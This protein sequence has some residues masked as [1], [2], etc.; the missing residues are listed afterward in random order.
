MHCAE[1]L[2]VHLVKKSKFYLHMCNKD[3]AK[4]QSTRSRTLP[5]I[6]CLSFMDTRSFLFFWNWIVLTSNQNRTVQYPFLP[7][8]RRFALQ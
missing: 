7:V 5:R 6:W 4:K 3:F 8:C 1:C 2:F